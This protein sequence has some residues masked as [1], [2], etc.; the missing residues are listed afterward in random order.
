MNLRKTC[1]DIPD[2]WKGGIA[3][4]CRILGEDG[5]PISRHTVERY[6]ALGRFG[7]GIDAK[8]GARGRKQIS[9]KEVKRLWMIL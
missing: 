4:V 2:N 5:K 1:P 3:D 8:I 9:G 7:G 6:I